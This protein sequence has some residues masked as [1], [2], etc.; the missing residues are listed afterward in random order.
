MAIQLLYLMLSFI[1]VMLSGPAVT[2]LWV[3]L[4]KIDAGRLLAGH[5]LL[6]SLAFGC[7]GVFV[8]LMFFAL[9]DHFIAFRPDAGARPLGKAELMRLVEEAFTRPVEGRQ[10]FE[11]ARSGDRLIVTWNAALDYFQVIS[12]GGRGM[13]RV[14]VL[15][16][17]EA[18]RRAFFVMQERD[19]KWSASLNAAELSLRFSTGLSAEFRTELYPSVD[20]SP[21]GGLKVELKKLTYSSDE[22][23]QP[24]QKAVLGAGWSL[25][26]GMAPGLWPRLLFALPLGL[27]FFGAGFFAALM[28]A[29]SVP[30]ASPAQA[31]PQSRAEAPLEMPDIE[32]QLAQ[33][34]PSMKT[35]MIG[36]QIEGIVKTPPEHLQ[37]YA[38]RALVVYINAYARREDRC[39]PL[40][41]E[42]V[43]FAAR[44]RLGGIDVPSGSK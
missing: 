43:A 28:A 35:E 8:T 22:L 4:F 14:V 2:L 31:V 36:V 1:G 39:E 21:Q 13:K 7:Y 18:R 5:G 17:D 12:A 11:V 16:F 34:L 26:G 15:T 33:V 38:R 42:A 23:W 9:Q 27:L 30:A 6:C 40:L 25:H 32:K 3:L 20:F 24:I 19:Y 37:E 41:R 44:L 10:L 29:N